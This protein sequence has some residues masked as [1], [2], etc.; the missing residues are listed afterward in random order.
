[1]SSR[2]LIIL[3]TRLAITLAIIHSLGFAALAATPNRKLSLVF[4]DFSERA[5]LLFVAKDQ[6]FFEEQGVDVDV[7]QVRN[8][9][10]AIAAVAAGEAQFYSVSATGA[11]LGA[12]AGGLDI[13][14]VA[15]F[16]NR[17]DGYFAVSTKV[18]APEDLKGKTLGVQSIGGGIWMFTQILLD[19]WG[20]NTERDKIQIRAIGDDSVL[21]QAVM[22]GVI[23]GAVLGYTYSRVISQKGGRILVELPT[24]NIKYQGTGLV[25]SRRFIDSSPDAVEK[26]LRALIRANR[27]IQDKNNQAGGYSQ[28][29]EMAAA[30]AD[31]QRRR[32]VQ[33]HTATLR[34]K[35]CADERRIQSA[36]Q[37]L[38]K[39][40]A[41]FAK[42]KADDLIDDRIARKLE[43]EGL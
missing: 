35:H 1:M 31:G 16:I 42:L 27:F 32:S 28:L 43:K 13:V 15:G 3:A 2:H 36:L 38:A 6:H 30:G 17:L 19:H 29:K 14:F 24:L 23:D 9:P 12:M 21:A 26:T 11:S 10:V 34:S 41:K 7:V 40:D 22:T 25:A 37:L 33:P 4:A 39:S 20:L 8:G 5:G 18:R